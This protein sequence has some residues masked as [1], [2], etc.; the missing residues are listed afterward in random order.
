MW[1]TYINNAHLLYDFGLYFFN[2]Y[3]R[4]SV[5]VLINSLQDSMLIG[6]TTIWFGIV[7]SDLPLDA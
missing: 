5:I 1:H 2:C 7:V 6:V 4:G 3:G